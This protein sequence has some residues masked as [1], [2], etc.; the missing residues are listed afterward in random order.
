M[1]PV[2]TAG[3][4]AS[5]DSAPDEPWSEDEP[6]PCFEVEQALNAREEVLS[7]VYQLKMIVRD[8]EALLGMLETGDKAAPVVESDIGLRLKSQLLKLL[9]AIPTPSLGTD[10]GSPQKLQF[11]DG[12]TPLPR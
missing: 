10:D 5:P 9:Q 1:H 7:E 8:T 6:R 2:T 3:H 12:D 11:E 4:E